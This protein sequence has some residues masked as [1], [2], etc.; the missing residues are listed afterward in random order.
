M[1]SCRYLLP[2]ILLLNL[3][4]NLL[5]AQDTSAPHLEKRGAATQLI[6]DGKP[7]LMLGAELHNSSSSSLDY[8]KP[9]WAKLAAVPLNTV[10]TPISWELVEPTEGKFDFTLID[11]LLAQAREY[12]LRIVFLWLASWKNGWSSYPPVWVKRDTQRFPRVVEYGNPVNILSTFAQATQEADARAF[13]AVMQHIREVDSRDHTVLM[14]QVENEVGVLR[15]TRDHS[16]IANQ[17]FSSPVPQELTRYLKD[18]K[19]SLDIELRTLWQA[20][21]EKTTGTWA[22]IFGDTSRA[23]EIFMAWY[24]ARFIQ[25]VTAKGKA[26]YA[27]PMYVNTWLAREDSVPGSFPSG[28]PQPRVIDIW[29]AAGSSIDLYS[30]DIY[31]PN[32]AWWCTRY[33]RPD[34]AL[35][36]PEAN[37]GA[38]GAANVFYAVG[39][40]AALGFSPFGID[41]WNDTTEDL[42]K[43]YST[44]ASLAPLILEQQTKGNVH[45]FLLDQSHPSAEFAMNGYTVQVTLDEIFGNHANTGFGLIIATGPDEFTGA[46]KGFRV[47]FTTRSFSPHT[48]IGTIDEGRFEDGRWIP[49]RRLNGD[50]NDQGNYWRFDQHEIKIEKVTLYHFE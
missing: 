47:S 49:G 21:G 12:R 41:S 22:Q 32:F 15:D 48:G 28:G 35:F 23:D 36:I 44:I 8:M 26:A 4:A 37:G 16:P 13:A 11:G 14:M 2:A 6:V 43:S 34:N 27:L 39:E 29:K 45:G 46:G 42:G 1:R 18:H 40:H 5:Y 24:Y 3:S 9:S 7:F 38:V 17:A 50:E 30:P 33:H 31:L 19:D 20:N 10:V 25:A